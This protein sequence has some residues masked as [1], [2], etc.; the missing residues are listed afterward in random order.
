LEEKLKNRISKGQEYKSDEEIYSDIID[1]AGVRIALYFPGDAEE[2]GRFIES[3]FEAIK[4]V[5]MFPED[6]KELLTGKRFS[7]YSA[8][9][10]IVNLKKDTLSVPQQRYSSTPI[11]I[12]VASVLM[13]AWAEVEHDLIY[14]PGHGTLSDDE[15]AILDELN[16]LVLSGEITLE[17][18]QKAVESRVAGKSRK[19]SNHYEL[20]AYLLEAARPITKGSAGELS[21]GRVDLLFKLLA[22]VGMDRPD[23]IAPLIREVKTISE[24]RPLAEQITDTILRERQDLYKTYQL[25]RNEQEVKTPYTIRRSRMLTN[26]RQQAVRA[27]MGQWIALENMML[28]LVR[29]KMP[30]AST[31]RVRRLLPVYFSK[32]GVAD[33]DVLDDI[34]RLRRL[35]NAVVHGSAIPSTEVLVQE[36]KSVRALTES[37]REMYNRGMCTIG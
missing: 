7:G 32:L 21:I 26:R 15:Y 25:I 10:Y 29:Q 36:G 20:A 19:F 35:R 1:L 33:K 5:R 8:R 13:H 9:H 2:V 6:S 30:R 23:K 12:Q 16:G 22:K 31:L 4:P 18:L 28:A 37:L 24:Q 14:K 11:E 3:R 34:Q 27:F 17:R